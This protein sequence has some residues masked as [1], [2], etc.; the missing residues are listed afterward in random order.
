MF[1]GVSDLIKVIEKYGVFGG[2]FVISF[3]LLIAFFK[4]QMFT[5]I[6]ENL[7]NQIVFRVKNSPGS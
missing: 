1:D 5:K 2:I 7:V 6:F 4:S 3:F